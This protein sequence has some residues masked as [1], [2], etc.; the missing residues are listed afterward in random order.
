MIEDNR[1]TVHE[2][3]T[4]KFEETF[5]GVSKSVGFLDTSKTIM[6]ENKE[7]LVEGK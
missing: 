2:K 7:S 5:N 6:D 1:E 4:A 3:F